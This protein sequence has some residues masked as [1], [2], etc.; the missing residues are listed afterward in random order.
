MGAAFYWRPLSRQLYFSLIGPSLLAAPWLAA[1]LHAG[2][3]ARARAH[4]LSHRAARRRALGGRCHRR[5]VL[6][7]DPARVLL[8]WPSGSQHLLAAVLAALAVHEAMAGRLWTAAGTAFCGVLSHESAGLAL[9]LIPL[10]VWRE[11]HERRATVRAAL[12]V[13]AVAAAWAIGYRIA[14]AHGVVMPPG[15]TS[16]GIGASIARLASVYPRALRAALGMEDTAPAVRAA[17]A[18]A[19]VLLVWTA[20]AFSWARPT[21]R[22]AVRAALPLALA[23]AAWFAAGVAPL[24]ALLPDWNAW[25][26][27]TPTVGFAVAAGAALGAV[28]P[29]LAGALV[30]IKLVAL[31]ASPLAPATISAS[32]PVNG[33]HVSF[34]QLV[35]LQRMCDATRRELR[36]A[37]P[38]LPRGREHRV[39]A[40]AAAHGVRVSRAR[41]RPAS[42]T[43]IRRSCGTGSA[44]PRGLHATSTCVLS[45]VTT[46]RN[47]WRSS[48]APRLESSS[49]ATSWRKRNGTPRS[50]RCSP[51]RNRSPATTTGH[52][53]RPIVRNRGF[54]AFNRGNYDEAARYARLAI[55][56][57]PET[58]DNWTLVA[59]LAM[60]HNDRRT[61]EAA[62]RRALELDPRHDLALDLAKDLGL[63]AETPAR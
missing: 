34:S 31:L 57:G 27:W 18:G 61:A 49:A 40:A 8:A 50:T 2:A 16:A 21:A 53:T 3:V 44:R 10:V 38:H 62:V 11:R 1:V 41:G 7:A 39:L 19:L 59:L 46:I 63:G 35:R 28:S 25:R 12:A 14:L 58:P 6:L 43:T 51:S 45:T 33:S 20:I 42:G 29:W 54:A 37:R 22:R 60:Q 17:L 32:P 48:L 30:A 4:R 24:A 55:D 56:R 5:C 13:L 9:P 23:G 47:S 52:T 15:A 36:R 26:A